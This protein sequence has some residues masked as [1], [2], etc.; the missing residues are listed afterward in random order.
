[1]SHSIQPRYTRYTLIHGAC[2]VCVWGGGGGRVHNLLSYRAAACT[3]AQSPHSG[4]SM[5]ADLTQPLPNLQWDDTSS[6]DI[7]PRQWQWGHMPARVTVVTY[8]SGR[9]IGPQHWWHMPQVVTVVAYASGSGDICPQQ[10]FSLMLTVVILTLLNNIRIHCT[11]SGNHHRH[12]LQDGSFW[13]VYVTLCMHVCVCWTYRDGTGAAC[14]VLK[15][16]E[17][18][19]YTFQLHCTKPWQFCSPPSASDQLPWLP[20][21]HSPRDPLRNA[22]TCLFVLIRVN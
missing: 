1:M 22:G 4:A 13:C 9:D 6:S 19:S 20:A 2:S 11:A 5:E 10:W 16:W 21:T 17:A 12:A 8:A 3:Y 15:L 7:C 18:H 14:T